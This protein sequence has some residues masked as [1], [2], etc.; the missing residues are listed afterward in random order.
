MASLQSLTV[1][2]TGYLR[3]PSGTTAQRPGSPVAGMMRYNTDSKV[4][5]FYDGTNWNP[6]GYFD[7][8]S[9]STAAT[10]GFTTGPSDVKG[11]SDS[12]T[13]AC[14]GLLTFEQALDFVHDLN[15][16]LPTASEIIS[17]AT[18]GTGCGYDNQR[19]WTVDSPGFEGDSHYTIF[20]RT[21]TNGTSLELRNNTST[22]YVRYVADVD[23][24]R[25]DPVRL[26]DHF[27][28]NYLYG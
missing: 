17:G 10:V 13:N 22:A 16:R 19:I 1:N 23:L 7:Y 4:K 3:M 14:S 20:G 25:T 12:L 6:L 28:Y 26:Y 18:V 8:I 9:A 27:I 2:D 5:E 21:D 24:S 11:E 15:V